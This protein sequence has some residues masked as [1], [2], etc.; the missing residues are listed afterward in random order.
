MNELYTKNNK[1]RK[2]PPAKFQCAECG[3]VLKNKDIKKVSY[4]F[5]C[6]GNFALRMAYRAWEDAKKGVE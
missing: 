4:C 5:H 3:Y 6:G 2:Y 1:L